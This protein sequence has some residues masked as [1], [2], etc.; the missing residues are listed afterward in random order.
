M[1]MLLRPLRQFRRN[2]AI[3][4]SSANPRN[5]RNGAETP[6]SASVCQH[7]RQHP[8]DSVTAY[9]NEIDP[10]KAAWLREL[11]KADLIAPGDVDE[12]DIWDVKPADLVRYTQCHFFAGIGIWSYAIRSAGWPDDRPVWTGSAPCQPFSTAGKGGGFADDRHLWPAWFWLIHECRP[13]VCF[14]E[15]VASRDGLAWFD[16]VSTD[17]E[18][19]G[20]AVG[21]LDLCAAGFGAPHIRQRLYFV[22]DAERRTPERHG[23][24]M[25][26]TPGAGEG[27]SGQRQRLRSDAGDG[28]ESERVD[29]HQ[30]T[31]LEGHGRDQATEGRD[32]TDGPTAAP[33]PTNGFWRDVI[34]LHCRDGKLRPAPARTDQPAGSNG[35]TRVQPD[36]RFIHAQPSIFPLA[37]GASE[38]VGRLRGY[39]DGIVAPVAEGFVRAYMETNTPEA[40]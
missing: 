19:A 14:G 12:R 25:G 1:R 17:L 37:H 26:G 39:G 7:M 8:G 30:R 28:G 21:A 10:K 36:P 35:G 16:L 13:P 31:G 23:H 6:K 34:W 22:A 9:Y 2:Q 4:P 24:E 20:Y 27:D 29:N 15:Q 11:I 33:G 40:S 32:G 18:G 3:K 5:R 38:R